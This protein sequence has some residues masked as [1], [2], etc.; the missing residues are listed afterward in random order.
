MDVERLRT[1]E[2]LAHGLVLLQE[3]CQGYDN[4]SYNKRAH[5]FI[6]LG[7]DPYISDH[8]LPLWVNKKLSASELIH[9]VESW[10]LNDRTA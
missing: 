5:R 4:P 1:P 7:G 10:L 3:L 8:L 9:A 6:A 2:A